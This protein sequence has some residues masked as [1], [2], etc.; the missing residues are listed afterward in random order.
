MNDYAETSLIFRRLI[1]G[2]SV[3]PPPPPDTHSLSHTQGLHACGPATDLIH[4]LCLS[5]C[6][7]YV[8]APCCYG[9]IAKALDAYR[10]DY[11]DHNANCSMVHIG[12]HQAREREGEGRLQ[13]FCED[14]RE[15]A[16]ER[17][18]EEAMRAVSKSQ[19]LRDIFI[20]VLRGFCMRA[21]GS[22]QARAG[23]EKHACA[24]IHSRTHKH[25]H[26]HVY[27]CN[28]IVI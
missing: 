16:R 20:L 14:E 11:V 21:S 1:P 25:T 7:A 5:A 8:L 10:L 6:A 4:G 27:I 9:A 23:K 12:Y 13:R 28:I 22:E 3:S 18:R 24:C 2:A 17:A 26:K 15:S 19:M